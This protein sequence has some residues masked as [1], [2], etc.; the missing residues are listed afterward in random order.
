MSKVA[1]HGL[2]QQPVHLPVAGKTD[3]RSNKSV[4][5]AT[6]F[7][8]AFFSAMIVG[9][10]PVLVGCLII[11]GAGGII[12]CFNHAHETASKPSQT[13]SFPKKNVTKIS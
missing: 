5:A 11:A 4:M 1:H 10:K 12:A 3:L 7:A 2:S 13:Q 9:F 6:V 8:I